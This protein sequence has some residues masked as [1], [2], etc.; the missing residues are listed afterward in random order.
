MAGCVEHQIFRFDIAMDDAKSM[1]PME[2]KQLIVNLYQG[3]MQDSNPQN[4]TTSAVQKIASSGST[5]S[6]DL[7]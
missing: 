1:E 4:L 5:L 7:A 6:S 2:A 3:R